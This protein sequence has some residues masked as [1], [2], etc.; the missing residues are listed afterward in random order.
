MAITSLARVCILL[1]LAAVA[2]VQ[3]AG[4]HHHQLHCKKWHSSCLKHEKFCDNETSNET[5][6]ELQTQAWKS[7][8]EIRQYIGSG[9]NSD[10]GTPT[11][12]KSDVYFLHHNG[13]FVTLQAYCDTETD[14]GGWTV[15]M[16]RVDNETTFD[17]NLKEYEEG[18]GDLNG[19]FWY[20]LRTLH[21]L[22]DNNTWELRVDMFDEND[23]M[24]YAHY[25]QFR[26]EGAMYHYRLFISAYSEDS[27]A[28]DGLSV[29]SM[30]RFSTRDND[31]SGARCS[32]SAKGGW[33]YKTSTCRGNS[34][35]ILTAKYGSQFFKWYTVTDTSQDYV[36]FPKYEVKIRPSN[37][38]TSSL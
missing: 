14:G 38:I 13:P 22:T 32:S 10:L 29:F 27:T 36:F 19:N 30:S 8:C 25:S 23:V 24:T 18:F 34:G 1:L 37:C 7:C 6:H 31:V 2:A 9:Y 26:V 17:R 35:S 4:A 15:I 12:L 16:R 5:A 3:L 11:G 33:W 28:A 21:Q 20:G